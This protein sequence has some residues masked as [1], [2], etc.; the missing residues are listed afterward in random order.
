[1][2]KVDTLVSNTS[3]IT[4]QEKTIFGVYAAW[5]EIEF[6]YESMLQPIAQKLTHPYNACDSLIIAHFSAVHSLAKV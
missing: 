3:D 2:I 6:G 4:R 5:D 1:M